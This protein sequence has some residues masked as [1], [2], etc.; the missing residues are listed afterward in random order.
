MDRRAGSL[1]PV[2]KRRLDELLVERGLAPS[3]RKARA[4]VMAGQVRGRDRLYTKP[5]LLLP[6]DVSL[7]IAESRPFVSRGGEKLD[8][9]FQAWPLRAGG[10]VCLDV[11]ASTGGFSDCLLQRGALRVFA[12]DSGRGQLAQRLRDDPRVES[13]ERTNARHLSRLEPAPSLVTVDVSFISART[14]LETVEGVASPGADVVVLV[15]PQFEAAREAVNRDGVVHEPDVRAAAVQSLATW[16]LARG[17]RAGGVMRSPL[18]GPAG[19]EEFLLWLRS[20]GSGVQSGSDA[21]EL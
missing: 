5:G 21:A 14:I 18:T 7:D 1:I 15:K 19:N 8:A 13:M 10:R 9:A 2:A 17:W 11:G 20:P 16:A 12:V 6:L 3:E 4:L